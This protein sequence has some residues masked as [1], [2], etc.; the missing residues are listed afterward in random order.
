MKGTH[1]KLK[2]IEKSIY[3]Q[4]CRKITVSPAGE[5]MRICVDGEII[6]QT[7]TVFEIVPEG[8]EFVVPGKLEYAVNKHLTF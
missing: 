3:S 4:K 8:F 1:P 7:E 6:D 5:Q 2:N